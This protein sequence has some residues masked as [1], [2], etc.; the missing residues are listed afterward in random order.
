MEQR[1]INYS[2][3][4]NHRSTALPSEASGQSYHVFTSQNVFNLNFLRNRSLS[5]RAS[6]NTHKTE[7][8]SEKI[9]ISLNSDNLGD[10]CIEK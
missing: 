10:G 9:N 8:Q 4:T 1:I 3:M 6:E 5:T 2:S 7:F